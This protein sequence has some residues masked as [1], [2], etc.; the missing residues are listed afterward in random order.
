VSLP[1]GAGAGATIV[2]PLNFESLGAANAGIIAGDSA[3]RDVDETASN[4]GGGGTRSGRRRIR[5]QVDNISRVKDATGEKVMESF[6]IFL[7]K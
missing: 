6:T 7:E 4:V 2:D 5:Q 3:A 1:T